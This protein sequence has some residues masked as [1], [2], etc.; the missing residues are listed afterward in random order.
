MAKRAGVDVPREGGNEPLI[1]VTQNDV[2]AI[3][4]GKAALYAGVRLL[5]DKL[6]IE[7][8]GK[9]RLAGAFGSH[10]DVKYAMILGLIPEDAKRVGLVGAAVLGTD[11]RPAPDPLP[12]WDTWAHAG[13]PAV[14]L[15]DRAAAVVVAGSATENPGGRVAPLT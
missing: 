1:R 11:R 12:G 7:Q 8:V 2:R 13:D 14:A 6:G 10:I 3:Q 9:I 15:L 5:M 4:L